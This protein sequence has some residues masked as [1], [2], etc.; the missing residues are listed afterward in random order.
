MP[1]FSMTSSATRTESVKDGGRLAARFGGRLDL[2][3]AA[4]L[5]AAGWIPILVYNHWHI[6]A[7]VI[8][9]GIGWV[10][11]ILCGRFFWSAATLAAQEGIAREGEGFELSSGRVA[12]LERE[13]RALLKA[14]KEIEFD[15]QMG[16]MSEADAGDITRVYRSRAID[17]I[18]ELEGDVGPPDEDAPLDTVIDREVRARLALAGVMPKRQP[19]VAQ[20]APGVAPAATAAAAGPAERV[21]ETEAP[22]AGK[23]VEAEAPA[24]EKGVMPEAPPAEKGVT[25]EAPAA[26]ASPA[27]DAPAEASPDNQPEAIAAPDPADEPA[28]K[29]AA[30]DTTGDEAS[31]KTPPTAERRRDA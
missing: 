17:V 28:D 2:P 25:P 12:E 27:P 4:V 1:S 15:R 5:V 14:I 22:A 3:I 10:G 30:E 7:P 6:T 29:P 9:L 13:K 18:K 19:E 21:V 24:A 16:K 20:A 23:A 8:F 26:A 11:V 31:E